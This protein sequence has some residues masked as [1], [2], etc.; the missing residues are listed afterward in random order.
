VARALIGYYDAPHCVAAAQNRDR[1]R[2]NQ[3]TL[4]SRR[5]GMM[6]TVLGGAERYL[7]VDIA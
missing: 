2:V 5:D 4:V 6:L 7:L 1:L 3:S